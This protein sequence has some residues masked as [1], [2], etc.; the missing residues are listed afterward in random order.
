MGFKQ[1]CALVCLLMTAVAGASRADDTDPASP[2]PGWKLTWSDEFNGDSIDRNH[3]NFETGNGGGWGNNEKEYYTDRPENAFVKD[4]ALHLRAIK[5]P[6]RGFDYTSARMQSRGKFSQKY[7]RFDF[8]AKLPLGAGLWPAMWM[9]P[10]DDA[11]GNWPLSGEIDVTEARGQTPTDVLGTLHFGHPWPHNQH[12][13]ATYTLPNHGTIA[14]WHLYTLE[15]EPGV[16]RWYV[17]GKLYSTKNRWFSQ[18]RSPG[19]VIAPVNP[20]PAPFDRPFFLILNVAVGGNFLHG[21]DDS[22]TFPQEMQVDYIRVYEKPDGYG[23]IQPEGPPTTQ[24]E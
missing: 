15:W 21:P 1:C 17:D 22:T 6:Y 10:Q 23:P 16:I 7:G 5:S 3:W 12:S 11:Y 13:G 18:P 24:P 9:M 19:D 14:D 4:G 2:P 20:W 8:R